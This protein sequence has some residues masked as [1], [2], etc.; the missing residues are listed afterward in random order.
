[1][2]KYFQTNMDEINDVFEKLGIATQEQRDQFLSFSSDYFDGK[3][4]IE[5]Y[6]IGDTSSKNYSKEGDEPI[7]KLE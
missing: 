3:P 2:T 1:M 7:A 5:T 6:I 4:L